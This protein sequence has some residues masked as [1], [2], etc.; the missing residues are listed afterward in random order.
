M[1][2]NDWVDQLNP[3]GNCMG[4]YIGL[5]LLGL[6][7]VAWNVFMYFCLGDNW[8]R[9]DPFN[10]QIFEWNWMEN[11][12]SWWPILHF[13]TFT[14]LSYTNPHC[15]KLLFIA[16]VLWE[17]LEVAINYIIKGTL[18]KQPMRISGGIQYSEIW[19][20]GSFK[21]ILF[22]TAGIIVGQQLAKVF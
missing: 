6:G 3:K 5:L 21:D 18:K 11:C 7:V 8:A 13:I 19:W 20:A 9:K 17:L 15:G 22:N 10:Q 1:K 14:I 4:A 2:I 12:C 16:G